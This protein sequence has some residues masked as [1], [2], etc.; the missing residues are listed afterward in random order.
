[1][2]KVLKAQRLFYGSSGA[3]DPTGHRLVAEESVELQG[4][5]RA[6]NQLVERRLGQLAAVRGGAACRAQQRG[7]DLDRRRQRAD[8]P[9]PGGGGGQPVGWLVYYL[10][11]FL[12]LHLCVFRLERS[13]LELLLLQPNC[14]S[15][16]GQHKT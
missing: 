3:A 6:C 7:R 1:M 8:G 5:L 12:P 9:L 13:S 14:D 4:A 11:L 16:D 15:P 10:L 2:S